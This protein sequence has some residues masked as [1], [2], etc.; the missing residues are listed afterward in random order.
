MRRRSPKTERRS[1]WRHRDFTLLWAGQTVSE[2]GSSV[3]TLALPLVAVLVLHATT[4]EVGALAACTNLPFLLVALPAGAWV[5]RWRKRSVLLRSDAGRVFVLGS[6]PVAQAFHHLGLVQLYVVALLA[7]VLTVFFDV[8]Y[9]SFLPALV[10]RDELVEATPS[11]A[12]ANPSVR[13][14]GRA[15]AACSSVRSVRPTPS[16]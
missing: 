6:V 9:Q 12:R 15:S 2:V 1:L 16:R 7:G 10:A 3:T 14:P 4:F 5:D 13:S 11:S 8:A